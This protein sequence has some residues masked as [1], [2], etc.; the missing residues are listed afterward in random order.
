MEEKKTKQP[1][2]FLKFISKLLIG[3]VFVGIFV[4]TINYFSTPKYL[5]KATYT[6]IEYETFYTYINVKIKTEETH[7]FNSSDFV[8]YI[9]GS[10][11]PSLGF[12]N[13]NNLSKQI[14]IYG[15]ETIKICF[16]ASENNIDTPIKLYL[17]SKKLEINKT[18]TIK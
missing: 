17:N 1:N 7:E 4:F 3:L 11:T 9:N 14:S 16:K 8:L 13:K 2:Y 6:S 15:E 10:P 5:Y 12:G 18:I